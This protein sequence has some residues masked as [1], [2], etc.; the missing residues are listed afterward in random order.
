MLSNYLLLNKVILKK[1]KENLYW[2]FDAGLSYL[3]SWCILGNATEGKIFYSFILFCYVC[4][5]YTDTFIVTVSEGLQRSRMNKIINK[6]N[7]LLVLGQ[8]SP[9]NGPSRL[10]PGRQS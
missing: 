1:I 2:I 3:S 5:R 4:C 9:T 6:C 8:R 7:A 10:V